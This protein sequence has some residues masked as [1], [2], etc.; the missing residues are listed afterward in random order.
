MTEKPSRRLRISLLLFGASVLLLFGGGC[1][2]TH[3]PME[4]RIE[5]L[6]KE[7]V[8]KGYETK[9]RPYNEKRFNKAIR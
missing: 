1:G 7:I 2:A 6:N 4:K 5:T 9:G 3:S 8:D